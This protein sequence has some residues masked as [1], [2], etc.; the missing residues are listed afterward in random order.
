MIEDWTE[1]LF[2]CLMGGIVTLI[3]ISVFTYE[4][5]FACIHMVYHDGWFECETYNFSCWSKLQLTDHEIKCGID[6]L[7]CCIKIKDIE[8]MVRVIE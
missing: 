1:I 6:P 2:V 7:T 4:P 3:L 5:D 8:E